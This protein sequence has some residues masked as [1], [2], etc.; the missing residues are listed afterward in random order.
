MNPAKYAKLLEKRKTER[1]LCIEDADPSGPGV[2]PVTF[3]VLFPEIKYFG[4][5]Y[6][7]Y[8]YIFESSKF[9]NELLKHI[10][11]SY[12]ISVIEP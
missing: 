11:L 2:Y 8:F 7:V 3:D 6:T 12:T 9:S 1:F 10:D 4:T 5:V